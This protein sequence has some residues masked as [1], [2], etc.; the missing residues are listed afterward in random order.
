MAPDT[1]SPIGIA[2]WKYDLFPYVL[3]GT[4]VS[5][6]PDGF[7]TAK[8]YGSSMFRPLFILPV[9]QG[10]ELADGMAELRREHEQKIRAVGKETAEK[11]E[12]L[13]GR[14]GQTWDRRKPR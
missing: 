13:F 6:E 7:V 9:E 14:Y 8:E 4:A 12:A 11:M 1:K 10:M 5:I 2:F 3:H